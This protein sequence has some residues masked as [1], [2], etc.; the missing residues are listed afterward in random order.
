[1]MRV[2]FIAND[3]RVVA[4]LSEVRNQVHGRWEAAF[5][6]DKR[7]AWIKLQSSA[8]DV[9]V[10]D[11]QMPG[12]DGIGFLEE[13]KRAYP[14]TQRIALSDSASYDVICRAVSCVHRWISKPCDAERLRNVID[15]VCFRHRG[16]TF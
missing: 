11:V 10:V 6:S 4:E 13:V 1:M 8:F 16:E 2:L 9:V 5:S 14:H 7:S 15:Q 12:I 3:P